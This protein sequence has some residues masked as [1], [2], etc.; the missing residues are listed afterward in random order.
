MW[1]LNPVL[2]ASSKVDQQKTLET[3]AT[4]L[5]KALIQTL[6]QRLYN[7]RRRKQPPPTNTFY[8]LKFNGYPIVG[9][10][11]ATD[12]S[13]KSLSECVTSDIFDELRQKDF[14]ELPQYFLVLKRFFFNLPATNR[15]L[16]LLII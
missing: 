7:G 8:P 14:F 12:L 5:N 9:F 16:F 13:Y 10:S 11:I 15:I 4:S 2:F 1:M 3:Y 6:S